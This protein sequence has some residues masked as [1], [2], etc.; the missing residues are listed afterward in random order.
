LAVVA[1]IF[2]V[3][4]AFEAYILPWTYR[5]V[6]DGLAVPIP[7][8][9]L[10]VNRLVRL[11]VVVFIDVA[12][13]FV[14]VRALLTKAFPCTYKFARVGTVPIPTFPEATTVA[15]L[16]VVKLARVAVTFGAFTNPPT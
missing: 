3:V 2:V 6:C 7:K 15:V 11:I 4:K 9:P 16:T 1:Y 12:K 13:I 14:V 8:N 5:V 10:W